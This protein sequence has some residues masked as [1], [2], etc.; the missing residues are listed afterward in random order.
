MHSRFC[1]KLLNLLLM[2]TILGACGDG[3]AGLSFN[4]APPTAN[5]RPSVG[6]PPEGIALVSE[7]PF[8]TLGVTFGTQQEGATVA[9]AQFAA[10]E[11]K[12]LPMEK[13]YEISIPNLAAGRLRTIDYYPAQTGGR[14]W[15]EVTTGQSSTAQ[16]IRVSTYT[17]ETPQR[18]FTYTSF[19][20]WGGNLVVGNGQKAEMVGEFVYGIPTASGDVPLSGQAKYSA[21]IIGAIV[22][23]NWGATGAEGTANLQFDF[24]AGT[25]SGTMHP[26][27]HDA[28]NTY[29]LGPYPFK[30]TVF[31][32]G[33]RT[34]SG[35]F[36]VPG[37][38]DAASSFEGAFTGPQAAELMAR[39]EAPFVV[40]NYG[41]DW[42]GRII[43]VLMGK[44]GIVS[45]M[46]FA[47]PR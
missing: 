10:I 33:S 47:P 42:Q 46:G 23:A 11:F 45:P 2:T 12:Y 3:G 29:D 9:P 35:G 38:P 40:D 4:P 36:D 13:V 16:D 22:G 34:F 26:I 28:W 19:G 30:N 31:S 8:R 17:Q 27:I 24:A 18:A 6:I 32:R 14:A 5:P 39:W 20:S 25:L 44:K 41:E 37:M 7:Q 43:G 21:T 1:L 15:N